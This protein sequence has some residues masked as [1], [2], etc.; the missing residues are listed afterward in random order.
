M[1]EGERAIIIKYALGERGLRD[2]AIAIHRE[3][4]RK[5]GV[6]GPFDPLSNFMSEVDNP[7]PDLAL[8][9]RYRRQVCEIKLPKLLPKCP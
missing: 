6:A 5:Y 9:A 8:R 7:V 2:Q 3:N 4:L 1:T